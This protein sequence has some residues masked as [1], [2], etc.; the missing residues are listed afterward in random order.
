M[1]VILRDFD[2]LRFLLNQLLQL[3]DIRKVLVIRIYLVCEPT[4]TPS[5]VLSLQVH[6]RSQVGFVAGISAAYLIETSVTGLGDGSLIHVARRV[7]C[8]INGYSSPGSLFLLLP[9]LFGS[10]WLLESKR[11]WTNDV[12]KFEGVGFLG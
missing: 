5:I 2:Q 1:E 12:V 3:L 8:E 9:V 7:P 11:V 10:L 4:P 6:W